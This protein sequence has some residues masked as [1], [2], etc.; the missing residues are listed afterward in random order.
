[1]C[2]ASALLRIGD[3]DRAAE[4]AATAIRLHPADQTGSLVDMRARADLAHA[5]LDRGRLDAAEEAL[6]P[7]WPVAPEHRRHSLVGRLEGVA[8]AL[9]EPRYLRARAAAALT[10]RIRAFAE[11]SAPRTLPAMLEPPVPR[12]E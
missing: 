11:N 8:G 4:R 2:T 3:P 12:A 7:V 10:D 5:E 6:T 9:A 1:M